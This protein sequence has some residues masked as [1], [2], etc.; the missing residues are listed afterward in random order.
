MTVAAVFCLDF[1]TLSTGAVH[2][3]A[4]PDSTRPR[5]G[6]HRFDCAPR[7]VDSFRRT[8][9]GF[10]ARIPFPRPIL[11]T[12]IARKVPRSCPVQRW[13]PFLEMYCIR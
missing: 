1:M 7:S 10:R 3:R 5:V 12:A 13:K 8:Q 6:K 4:A 9:A 11:N 2:A